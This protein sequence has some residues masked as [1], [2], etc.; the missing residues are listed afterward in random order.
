M[1]LTLNLLLFASLS[2]SAVAETYADWIDFDDLGRCG[3]VAEPIVYK[4]TAEGALTADVYAL[5]AAESA[6]PR[7]ALI[8]VHGGGWTAGSNLNH[9]EHSRYF[10]ARGMV[11]L[12]LSYRLIPNSGSGFNLFGQV[13]DIRSALRWVRTHAAD[14]G[15][16]PSKLAIAGESAGGHLAAC[17]SFINA[18]DDPSENAAIS[19][20][21][22]LT[23]LLNPITDL[24]RIPWYG[25]SA[26]R[27]GELPLPV[28]DTPIADP[29]DESFH[30]ARRLSPL[31]YAAGPGQPPT[32]FVHGTADGVVPYAQ[33]KSLHDALLSSGHESELAPLPGSDH[34]F[35]IPG[36]GSK[37]DITTT[38][39]VMDNFLTR[40]GYLA[41]PAPLL[42]LD[43]N[44]LANGGFEDGLTAWTGGGAE[45]VQA[46][47]ATSRSHRFARGTPGAPLELRQS[48]ALDDFPLTAGA[49]D[50]ELLTVVV[51]GSLRVAQES[52]AAPARAIL[53]CFNEA[54]T[55]LTESALE[56]PAV[57]AG[58]WATTLLERR[59]PARTSSFE[60]VLSTTKPAAI[61]FDD[62]TLSL[63]START[64]TFAEWQQFYFSPAELADPLVS[65][66]DVSHPPAD[67]PHL[68]KYAF[69]LPRSADTPGWPQARR[70]PER[71]GLQFLLDPG[72]TDLDYRV[73]TRSDLTDWTGPVVFSS[74]TDPV[75]PNASCLVTVEDPV[76]VAEA[77]RRFG[78]VEILQRMATPLPK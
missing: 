77:S 9:R 53:R 46:P 38:L 76:P 6:P 63:G 14:L 31:F 11:V 29:L 24:P 42:G 34:A 33:S 16:D 61:D 56:W 35:F 69:R 39:L 66:P 62:F 55:L 78:R 73:I 20:R 26:A 19:A 68:V 52:D 23:L 15:I 36:Y 17:A 3:A 7:A 71:L 2:A 40:H 65:G 1:R 41:G 75:V 37:H 25:N 57:A 43:L 51:R 50:S 18:F 59:V 48:V 54:G 64:T 22:N 21:P 30:P 72:K 74:V 70:G 49:R 12:N 67:P 60:L 10:A 47:G 4:T 45:L 13:G 27:V 32:L 8:F 44:R 28:E 5:P 58:S